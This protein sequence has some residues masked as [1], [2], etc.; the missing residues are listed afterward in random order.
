MRRRV[1][2]SR[3]GHLATIGP[4][5]RPHIVPITFALDGDHLF[6]AVDAKPKRTL[7]LQRV[8]NIDA[9]PAVSVLVDHY[10][11]DWDRLWWVRIDGT[12][13]VLTDDAG[14]Q[15]ALDLLAARYVR[16]R[17]RRP[18]GPVVVVSIDRMSGWSAS[19][20]ES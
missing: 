16:Y 10:E 6:F 19:P 8:R 13:R 5:G 1:S 11:D 18:A 12:A 9:K 17:G 7:D 4:G 15:Q 14:I 2:A 20:T 3:V